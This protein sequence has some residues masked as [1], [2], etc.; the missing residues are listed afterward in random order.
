MLDVPIGHKY[1]YNNFSVTQLSKVIDLEENGNVEQEQKSPQEISQPTVAGNR[2][3]IQQRHIDLGIQIGLFLLVL[4]IYLYNCSPTAVVSSEFA[5]AR[6]LSGDSLTLINRVDYRSTGRPL[7]FPLWYLSA[8]ILRHLPLGSLPYRLNL[9]SSLFGALS[10]L[11][12]YKIIVRYKHDRFLEERNRIPHWFFLQTFPAIAI[13][14]LF[15]FSY[16]FWLLSEFAAPDTMQIFLFLLVL[17]FLFTAFRE[18][19]FR[20]FYYC[21]IALAIGMGVYPVIVAIS[22]FIMLLIVLKAMAIKGRSAIWTL[23]AIYVGGFLLHLYHPITYALQQHGEY[24]QFESFFSICIAVIKKQADFLSRAKGPGILNPLILIFLCLPFPWVFFRRAE[25][26]S[27]T[28]RLGFV[29]F[30]IN[31]LLFFIGIF[32]LLNMDRRIANPMSMD[33]MMHN[34]LNP[35]LLLLV[36]LW[37]GYL[38]GYFMHLSIGEKLTKGPFRKTRYGGASVQT[39][40]VLGII[41]MVFLSVLPIANARMNRGPATSYIDVVLEYAQ[42]QSAEDIDKANADNGGNKKLGNWSMNRPLCWCTLR[43]FRTHEELSRKILEKITEARYESSSATFIADVIITNTPAIAASLQYNR[44]RGK[45]RYTNVVNTISFEIEEWYYN[46]MLKHAFMVDPEASW[47]IGKYGTLDAIYE[48]IMN[49]EGFTVIQLLSKPS[50]SLKQHLDEDFENM[51][52]QWFSTRDPDSLHNLA[53]LFALT[54]KGEKAQSLLVLLFQKHPTYFET[55]YL[56]LINAYMQVGEF[57]SA[58]KLVQEAVKI[59]PEY[60]FL[61]HLIDGYAYRSEVPPRIDKAIESFSN[62]IKMRPSLFAYNHLAT[63]YYQKEDYLEAYKNGKLALESLEVPTSK[64][65]EA[66]VL[67]TIGWIAFTMGLEGDEEKAEEGARFLRKAYNLDK[68]NSYILMH[69][70][71]LLYSSDRLAEHNRGLAMVMEVKQTD[72][73]IAR[74]ADQIL[75]KIDEIRRKLDDAGGSELPDI[76]DI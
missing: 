65:D 61:E 37:L 25:I 57:N 67:D 51:S 5:S 16:P 59:K 27:L 9:I 43:G 48:G 50:V 18:R 26:G 52:I 31:F 53:F 68:T 73:G 58:R 75:L 3:P 49:R 66:K 24:P 10:V 41:L 21:A 64:S 28:P 45:V 72:K 32:F 62:S 63:L 69:Y 76:P 4:C 70:G 22:P 6:P 35:L 33:L 40:T 47:D 30:A 7:S 54:N 60:R 36:S 39:G 29:H 74:E 12:L 46:R 8:R 13:S 14:L 15:A 55:E 20:Y 71:A 17:Y 11:F 42:M 2:T 34:M 38:F 1:N 44:G 19:V 23:I 56:A